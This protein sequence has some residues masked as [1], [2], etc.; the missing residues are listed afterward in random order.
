MNTVTFTDPFL[1]FVLFY[2]FIYRFGV[3]LSHPNQA[4]LKAKQLFCLDNLLRK[5]GNLGMF[6]VVMLGL[7]SA[8]RLSVTGHVTFSATCYKNS[9]AILC[10]E[11]LVPILRNVVN[12]YSV[13]MCNMRM[14]LAYNCVV[15]SLDC[16]I[17]LSK[18]FGNP[19]S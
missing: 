2:I 17:L 5:K 1:V 16:R 14:G 12:S 4:L 10:S 11:L 6:S 18:Q 8:I 13:V 7:F 19:S 15:I 9:W 3:Q